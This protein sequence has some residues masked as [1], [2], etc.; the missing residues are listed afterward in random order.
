[1]FAFK[2]L[3]QALGLAPP[4]ATREFSLDE[5][6]RAVLH[7]LANL[8]QRPVDEI[9]NDLIHQAL[10]E[11]LSVTATMRMWNQI[12]PRQQEVTALVCL[13]YTNHQIAARLN[14]SPETVKSHVRAVLRRFNLHSKTELSRFFANW[15]FHEWDR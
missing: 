5:D 1:M 4:E 2:R 15:D 8:E 10:D 14:I 3:L 13:G 7:D 12:T 9:A 6:L 11:R